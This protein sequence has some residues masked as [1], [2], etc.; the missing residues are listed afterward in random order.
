MSQER[1]LK[2]I[3][4]LKAFEN[5]D[6]RADLRFTDT[7]PNAP[8]A[9]SLGHG[10]GVIYVV[11][12]GDHYAYLNNRDL[13]A[14]G[15]D[16]ERLHTIALDNLAKLAS[17]SLN[18]S[19]DGEI[20]TLLMGGDFEASLILLDDLWEHT[21]ADLAPN[22]FVV[23]IPARDMLAFTDAQSGNGAAHLRRIVRGVA[24]RR[25]LEITPFLYRRDGRSWVP[26]A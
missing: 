12:E 20:H 9:T 15:L 11:D 21:F 26:M 7:D 5:N 19:S 1:C 4:R 16:M 6:V 23:A 22:G 13:A 18:R 17:Q 2:A 3:A 25:Q 10:L 14:S 8:L 24:E